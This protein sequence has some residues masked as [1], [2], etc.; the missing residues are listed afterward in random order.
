MADTVELQKLPDLTTRGIGVHADA[1]PLVFDLPRVNKAVPGQLWTGKIGLSN[2]LVRL[3]DKAEWNGKL[4]I[5][6]TPAV[7]TERALDLLLSDIVLQQGYAFAACDKATPGLVLR[8]PS[9]TIAEWTDVY[10]QLTDFA[11]ELVEQVYGQKPDKTYISGASNGGYVTRRMIELYPNS[12]DGAVEWEGVFWHPEKRHLMTQLPVYVA[13]YPIYFNWRGDRTATERQKA[14]NRLI[15]A[16]LHP[17]SEPYWNQYFLMYWLVSIW[18]YGRNIDPTWEP[19]QQEWSNDWLRDPS[20]LAGYPW[21]ERLELMKERIHPI[22]N[23]GVV[24]KPLLS[25][26]GNWDCLVPFRHNAQAYKDYVAERGFGS[27][28][29]LYEIEAGN[30][31]DGLLKSNKGNQQPVQPYYEAALRYLENW[32]EQGLE[33]PSSG[34]YRRITD[35]WQGD[36]LYSKLDHY[37]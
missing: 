16:G 34:L 9:R 8:D 28:H 24:Q 19:F 18:L 11:L 33:P 20:P 3:P 25:V 6:A 13:D 1:E 2:G 17:D 12:F 36:A 37:E 29:R 10:K 22:A 5:G 7:R 23:T 15:D 31:V 4:M 35:F 26:A 14:Y 27:N 30:H 32:V 21:Q